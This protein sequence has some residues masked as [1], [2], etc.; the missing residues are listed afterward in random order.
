MNSQRKIYIMVVS[1]LCAS[2]FLFGKSEF[3]SKDIGNPK[4]GKTEV[5]GKTIKLCGAGKDIWGSSDQ[6]RYHYKKVS[7]DME[8]IVKTHS[9]QNVHPWSKAGIMLRKSD[10]PNAAFV[11]V[12]V[13]PKLVAMQWRSKKGSKAGSSKKDGKSPIWLKLVKKSKEVS[14]HFSADGEKWQKI[15][16]VKLD[17]GDNFLA[18][19]AVTSHKKGK[20]C[21]AEFSDFKVNEKE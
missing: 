11:M 13:S 3:Q 9:I 14:C 10:A 21:C 12:L 4:A 6:F 5:K 18:G 17:L 8:V 1:I 16:S 15:K 7:G 2:V 19:M 20:L